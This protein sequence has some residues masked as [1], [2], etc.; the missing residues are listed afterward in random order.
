MVLGRGETVNEGTIEL[1]IWEPIEEDKDKPVGTRRL[2][3]TRDRTYQEVYEE[4]EGRLEALA[5]GDE[6]RNAS[7]CFEYCCPGW[8]PSWSK[9]DKPIPTDELRWVACYAVTGGSEGHYIHVDLIVLHDFN[10]RDLRVVHHLAM[11][12]TFMGMKHARHI[13]GVCADMLDA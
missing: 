7:I 8:H 2:R 10:G 11:I 4:I 13:A 6:T 1:S 5:E 12:K 9:N 3:K